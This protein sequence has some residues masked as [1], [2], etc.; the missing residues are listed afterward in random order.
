MN[1]SFLTDYPRAPRGR[2]QRVLLHATVIADDAG[3]ERAPVNV[4][5]VLD[6]SG[7]MGGEKMTATIEAA[8]CV[9]DNLTPADTI[10]VAIYDD[11]IDTLVAPTTVTNKDGIKR[12]IREIHARGSTNL[13]GG[14]MRGEEL[15]RRSMAANAVSRI[16][17]MT[18]GLANV[19]VTDHKELAE[20]ARKYR[21]AGI[22]T[23]TLGFGE[24]FNEDLLKTIADAGG[25]NFY[26]IAT[27]DDAPAM[28]KEELGEL[29]SQVAAD[30]RLSLTW[31]PGVECVRALTDY[32]KAADSTD[33][34]LPT[35][36][37]S[38]AYAGDRKVLVFELDLPAYHQDG[39]QKLAIGRLVGKR[40][41]SR[42]GETI[43]L[44]AEATIL[45][46][47]PAECENQERRSQVI[48]DATLLE[49]ALAQQRAI[50]MA[51]AGD[52]AGATETLQQMATAM[53]ASPVQTDI[54][55]AEL[56]A[57]Q[58]QSEQMAQREYSP[59]SRK[60][61]FI[62]SHQKSRK[63]GDYKK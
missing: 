18:D 59:A 29:Q 26:F 62:A 4:G 13:A 48:E 25:G 55:Q 40:V 47:D 60:M 22:V 23:T 43:E 3:H 61:M 58:A 9:V 31:G 8:C 63:K 37:L 56:G 50:S 10:S 30:L 57:V 33:E 14:W 39:E 16:L 7:S 51:D 12:R 19:G 6:R 24:R 52:F 5:L 1:L 44:E 41:G 36:D 27:P 32:P 46:A 53:A 2:T 38:A 20:M 15:V 54:L 45:V 34:K 42:A 49:V 35:Y 28:F 21:A 11:R 17:L